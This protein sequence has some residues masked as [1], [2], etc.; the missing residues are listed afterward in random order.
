MAK[1]HEP[2]KQLASPIPV[3][4]KI[5]GLFVI[6]TPKNIDNHVQTY[7]SL[8]YQKSNFFFSTKFIIF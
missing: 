1:M 3:D 5:W 8:L 4:G 2:L 6:I 7:E